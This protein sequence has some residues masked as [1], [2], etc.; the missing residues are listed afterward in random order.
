MTLTIQK[1]YLVFPVNTEKEQ[2]LLTLLE[3]GMHRCTLRIRLD[4]DEPNFFAYLDV[5][6]FYGKTISLSVSPE[7]KISFCETDT[8]EYTEN[9]REP[10][11]PQVHFTVKNGWLN[12]PNGLVR[13]GDTYHLFYQYNPTAPLAGSMHWGHATS[14]DLLHWQEGDPALFPD[15]TGDKWSGSAIVDYDNVSGLDDGNEP[16]VLLYYTATDPFAQYVAYSTDGLK[17]VKKYGNAPVVGHIIRQNRDPKVVFCEERGD[18]L[19]AIHLVTPRF[20]LLCSK[21]LLHW[22]PLQ[23]IELEQDGECPDLFPL[24]DQH[25]KRHWLFIGGRSRYL[26][27]DMTAE[28][29]IPVQ[30]PQS[31]Y[32]GDVVQAGQTFSGLP[33][34]RIVRIDWDRWLI[35]TPPFAG[36]MSTPY[37]LTLHKQDDK[38][39]LCAM[40]IMELETLFADEQ[41]VREI[42]ISPDRP[43][44]TALEKVPY[45][46]T[47]KA[48]NFDNVCL[49]LSIFGCTLT[50]DGTGNAVTLGSMQSPLRR[51]GNVLDLCLVIDRCSIECF[52]DG[53][54]IYLGGVTPDTVSDYKQPSISLVSDA[55]CRID[56]LTLH[57]LHSIWEQKHNDSAY[58]FAV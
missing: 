12:D 56:A 39:W 38:Y 26:V 6:R 43:W 15:E 10:N 53:G 9:Y 58:F 11:R 42:E 13:V 17:T 47:L 36:Q 28:G 50:I 40:P 52:L 45:H 31:L 19:M 7:A 51:S 2:A 55:P 18:Y 44:S 4:A 29:F 41:N 27:G 8:L 33:N 30:E 21:D 14:R 24:C 35:D 32:F 48:N 20:L 54:A 34:G 37:E 5:S 1:K 23:K 22:E 49:S 25:G 46:L 57:P 16:P 3:N